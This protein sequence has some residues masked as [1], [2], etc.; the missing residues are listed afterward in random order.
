MDLCHAVA[1]I[2]SDANEMTGLLARV[3]SL[4]LPAW[5]PSV[6]TLTSPS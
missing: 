6:R 2:I 3:A 1:M 5:P 4:W